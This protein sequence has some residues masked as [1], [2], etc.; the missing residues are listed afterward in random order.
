ML[1]TTRRWPFADVLNLVVDLGLQVVVG[2]QPLPQRIRAVVGA[3]LVE[4]AAMPLRADL[5]LNL[6]RRR[7]AHELEIDAR[8]ERHAQREVCLVGLDASLEPDARLQIALLDERF[9]DALD[10]VADL[11]EVVVVFRLDAERLAHRGLVGSRREPSLRASATFGVHALSAT[12]LG[13]PAES[14]VVAEVE[15]IAAVLLAD[16]ARLEP[17]GDV[18]LGDP[19]LIVAVGEIGGVDELQVVGQ[20]L[21]DA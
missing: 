4:D 5:V 1:N 14:N 6:L 11:E 10:A 21:A 15:S 7:R 18:V 9:L 20:L 8:S 19:D 13:T 2:H 3:L 17:A 16:A 12:R